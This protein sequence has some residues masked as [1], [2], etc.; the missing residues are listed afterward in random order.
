MSAAKAP[1]SVLSSRVLLDRRGPQ[2]VLSRHSVFGGRRRIARRI[3][4][5]VGY[6]ADQHGLILFVAV[7]AIIVLNIL[8]AFY[9]MLFLSHGGVEMNPFV[10]WV[11]RT[12]GVWMFLLVKSVGIGLCVGF[13]TVT[14]NFTASRVGLGIV[15]VGYLALLSWHWHLL[16]YIR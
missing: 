10:D 13:L 12:G 4:E 15:L 16:G 11:L 1:R 6:I 2:G 8:D 14:K 5:K 7:A 9:T 3:G